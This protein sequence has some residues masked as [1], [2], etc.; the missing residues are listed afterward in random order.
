MLGFFLVRISKDC[1]SSLNM[2]ANSSKLVVHIFPYWYEH[3]GDI[4]N[5][6]S[7]SNNLEVILN[8]PKQKYTQQ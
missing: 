6:P 4:K 8:H 3:I 2:S 7:D 5:K 1:P